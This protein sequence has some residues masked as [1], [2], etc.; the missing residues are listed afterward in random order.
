[1]HVMK[2]GVLFALVCAAPVWAL[3]P[4][5]HKD[6]E[7]ILQQHCQG[8]H[9]A[10]D[11]A[12]MPLV[13]Y[14]QARPWAKAIRAAVAQ[15]KMPPWFAD[16]PHNTFRNDQSLSQAEAQTIQSWA[17]AGA[18]EGDPKDAPSPRSFTEGWHIG[19]PD[20]VIE[21]PKAFQVPAQGTVPYQ[22]IV[23]P[24][25]FTEDKWVQ[26]V[27]IRPS[28]RKVVHHIIASSNPPATGGSARSARASGFFTS[29]A[30][31]QRLAKLKPGEEPP[32]FAAARDGE[33]LQVFVPG[34][35][36]PELQSGQAKLIKAGSTIMFQLHYTTIGTPQED[37]TSVGFIFAKEP[38]R[39]RV[40]GILVYNTHFTIP[41]GASGQ[42]IGA[43]AEVLHDMKMISMLPHMHLRGKDFQ[44]R[45]IYPSGESE[46]LL[47]VPH[48]D[49]NWQINYYLAQPKLLPK[50][51][52]IECTGHYDNSL[53]NPFNPDAATDVHYGEQT[54][55]E[56]LNGFMEVAI[57]PNANAPELLGRGDGPYLP[58]NSTSASAQ[59][60]GGVGTRR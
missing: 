56:M 19:T 48:Y 11:I 8:C 54:W 22:Y 45:V 7:P 58:A 6:V 40:K 23:V 17:D 59:A 33:L 42:I 55:E 26:A 41:A 44:F 16:A 50:G 60:A 13:T 27:E 2:T 35:Q 57:E 38:P 43:R 18:I 14:E 1:M 37:Q 9:H 31:K 24:T 53:N 28:N 32:Q 4:T 10:G 36:P 29:D 15:K 25:N 51:T 46:V 39:E 20:S 12:P 47:R 34:G 52:I 5:F 21:I 3:S 49:F 30:E